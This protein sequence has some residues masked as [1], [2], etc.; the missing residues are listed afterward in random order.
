MK[1]TINEI[2]KDC[3]K[4][5]KVLT[6]HY[7][8]KNVTEEALAV[9]RAHSDNCVL[10]SI[11][12]IKALKYIAFGNPGEISCAECRN[13][14]NKLISTGGKTWLESPIDDITAYHLANCLSC[15]QEY[16]ILREQAIANEKPALITYPEFDLSFLRKKQKRES[17]IKI[18]VRFLRDSTIKIIESSGQAIEEGFESVTAS[19]APQPALAVRV[20]PALT[21]DKAKPYKRPF[22]KIVV[23]VTDT[24]WASIKLARN[25]RKLNDVSIQTFTFDANKQRKPAS[26]LLIALRGP[27][28]IP[29]LP[30]KTSIQGSAS[31]TEPQGN[32]ILGI[33]DNKVKLRQYELIMESE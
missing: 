25:D 13:R 22:V 2:N 19:L 18:S 17:V 31:F 8:G 4:A 16:Q 24:I 30:R 29:I 10:C 27:S 6:D 3:I 26:G 12:S 11:R 1:R 14:L 23:K 20:F 32:Y 15:H 9:A 28:K 7:L 33:Y 5:S 21:T